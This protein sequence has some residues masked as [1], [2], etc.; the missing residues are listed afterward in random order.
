MVCLGSLC[1]Q[2]LGSLTELSETPNLLLPDQYRYCC[3]L[4][5]WGGESVIHVY[6]VC[7]TII[8]CI[9]SF[10]VS[11]IVYSMYMLGVGVVTQLILHHTKIMVEFMSL[12]VFLRCE[13]LI[14]YI[15]QCIYWGGAW[16]HTV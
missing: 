14:S 8:P 12:V 6:T 15:V 11:Y 5:V 4:H 10:Q 16:P 2:G 7:R 13:E 3:G 1:V 9:A